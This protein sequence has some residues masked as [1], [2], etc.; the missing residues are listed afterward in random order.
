MNTSEIEPKAK[1]LMK[2][3]EKHK[4]A[5]IKAKAFK[6][7]QTAEK[8]SDIFLVAAAAYEVMDALK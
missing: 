6:V 1:L 2:V 7:M 4:P 8:G 5:A 3:L